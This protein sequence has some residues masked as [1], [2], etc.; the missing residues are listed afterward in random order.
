MSCNN[1]SMRL[2]HLVLTRSM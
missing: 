2:N 1:A